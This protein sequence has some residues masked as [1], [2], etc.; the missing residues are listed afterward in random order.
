VTNIN[1]IAATQMIDFGEVSG[2]DFEMDSD[3]AK[4][5]QPAL[6]PAVQEQTPV[7]SQ[8]GE[9]GERLRSAAR[10]RTRP[11]SATGS[12]AGVPATIQGKKFNKLYLTETKQHLINQ[13]ERLNI[14]TVYSSLNHSIEYL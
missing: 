11:G 6:D 1:F 7:G 13:S 8:F 4:V 2:V 10:R 12:M 14:T 9:A 5:P 3:E